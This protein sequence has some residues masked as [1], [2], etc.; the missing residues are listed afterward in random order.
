MPTTGLKLRQAAAPAKEGQRRQGTS[1]AWDCSSSLLAIYCSCFSSHAAGF[2]RMSPASYKRWGQEEVRLHPIGTGPFMLVT[3]EQNR[4]IVLE[5]H[6]HYFKP[7]LPYLDRIEFR[8]MKEGV[9]RETALRTGE[10]DFANE[11]PHEHVERLAKDEKIQL[12]KGRD[13]T[14]Q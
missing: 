9:T 5:K 13:L 2:L 7:G 10:V 14:D 3:W 1:I 4:A 6:P 12:L 11:V 8:I